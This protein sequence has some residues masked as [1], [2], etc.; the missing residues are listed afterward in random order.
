MV[1]VDGPQPE[2]RIAHEL[3]RGNQ[4]RRTAVQQ[5]QQEGIDEPHVVIQRN[6]VHADV[7]HP[8]P[9]AVAD[10]ADVV[11]HRPVGEQDALR[12]SGRTGRVLDRRRVVRSRP[13]PG[14]RR[15]RLAPGP[16]RRARRRPA[17]RAARPRRFPRSRGCNR[18]SAPPRS[19]ESLPRARRR[20]R[21]RRRGSTVSRRAR[22]RLP[23]AAPRSRPTPARVPSAGSG[24]PPCPARARVQPGRR[25]SPG[26]GSTARRAY[27]AAPRRGARRS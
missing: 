18:A 21:G 15:P 8:Q 22:A 4:H 9:E 20:S 3:H 16:G 5:R 14:S 2:A 19:R 12:D 27:A 23:R 11:E 6:P 10:R 1:A 7:A 26:P 13:Q 25:G 17:A 24:S